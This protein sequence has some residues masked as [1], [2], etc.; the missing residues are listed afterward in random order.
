[1]KIPN[2]VNGVFL[3]IV[4]VLGIV[5]LS[6]FI[7]S[8][9]KTA[10]I[11]SSALILTTFAAIIYASVRID[12]MN[13]ELE[14]KINGLNEEKKQVE[15]LMERSLEMESSLNSLISLF[16]APRDVDRAIA[17]TLERTG[18]FCNSACNYLV[19]LGKDRHS[20]IINH[21]WDAV[22]GS[23]RKAVF[24][25]LSESNFPWLMEQIR[26]DTRPHLVESAALPKAAT[27]ER[28]IMNTRAVSSMVIV[29][30]EIDST[31][32]GFIAIEDPSFTEA[33]YREQLPALKILSELTGMAIQHKLFLE[34]LSLFKNLINESSDFIFVIDPLTGTIIDVNETACKELGYSKEEFLRM[35]EGNI[36]QV[37]GGRFWEPDIRE[38][39]GNRFLDIDRVIIRKDKTIVPVEMNVTF[40]AHEKNRYALVIARD[41]TERKE[42]EEILRRTQERVELALMGADLGMW[43]WNIRTN[44]M[45][46]NERWA[47]MLD[48]RPADIRPNFDS[49][50]KLIHPEDA[51]RVMDDI[52]LHIK[53]DRYSFESE[54][55]MQHKNTSF[56]WIQARGKLVEYDSTGEPLRL[57]GTTMDISERKQCE[58]ELRK[59]NELKDLFTD[60]MRHDLLNPAGN[61]KGY[62]DLLLESETTPKQK[63]LMDGISRNNDKLI[64]MIETAAKFA[65]L[66]SVRDIQLE[67]LDLGAILR[68]C[69]EQFEH[70]L[71]EKQMFLEIRAE[72]TFYSSVNPIVEEIFA[73]FISN[74][75][76]YSQEGTCIILEIKDCEQQWKVEVADQG[77][78]IP[79]ELKAQVFDRFKRVHKKGVKGT[80]L[81]L[82]IVKRIAEIMEGEVGVEDNP[83][84]QGS[85]FWVK[86]KKCDYCPEISSAFPDEDTD[87]IPGEPVKRQFLLH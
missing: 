14:L 38:I 32:V 73:N 72:G 76:K 42:V 68:S 8:G 66:E 44:E 17:E 25:N 11:F 31:L 35:E 50:K 3:L 74:A 59:S 20:F 57:A 71:L 7:V 58:E 28:E 45:I 78:G 34:D 62:S 84:G 4:C 24:E 43:D 27:R 77:E 40:T 9:E 54:F 81:G 23:G 36:E 2:L 79:D 15:E 82:A 60:I 13:R 47:E 51:D 6:P 75:I 41:V 26:N 1:M 30:T 52:A 5:V 18:Q 53:G 70:K 65:K 22:C 16:I 10:V 12:R 87:Y 33:G 21:R 49:W 86:L 69:A 56:R 61:I 64:E 48:Y 46:F 19:L 83:A 29:P 80:G 63:L 85:I 37:F 55:R 67:I 39:C